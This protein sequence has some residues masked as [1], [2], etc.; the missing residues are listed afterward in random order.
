MTEKRT[1]QVRDV[2]QVSGVSVRTLHYYDEIGLLAPS[3]RTAAGY[4]LYSD[5][6]LLRLQQILIGRSLGLSLNE[7]QRSLDEPGFDLAHRLRRQRAV[8]VDRLTETHKMIAA[9]DAT[10]NELSKPEGTSMDFTTIFDG[11]DPADF[12]AEARQNWGETEA[13][14]HSARRTD[15]YTDQEWRALKAE[16][17]AIWKAAAA[18]MRAGQRA[19]GEPALAVAERHR[20]YICRWFY[21]LSPDMHARLAELWE[22]DARFADTINSHG[23]GLTAWLAAAVRAAADRQ[24]R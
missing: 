18:A 1:Y 5:R 11:F 3:G 24:S 10:L 16:Q 23:E 9:I 17:D 21:D 20:Q 2:A 19:D 7:I 8:L 15:R 12:E 22:T 4:R 14:R 6:D 13:Y